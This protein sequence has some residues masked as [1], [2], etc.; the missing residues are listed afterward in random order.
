MESATKTVFPPEKVARVD[1]DYSLCII[2]QTKSAATLV[3]SPS[4]Y[5]KIL[6]WK[7]QQNTV[8]A[9]MLNRAK[10]H[11]EKRLSSKG[12][13]DEK[14]S[15]ASTTFTR[16][17]ST[18]Y[19]S[20]LCFFCDLG[21]TRTNSLHLLATGNAS[22]SLKEAIAKSGDE[23]LRVKLSTSINPTDAHAIDVKYH[24][25]CWAIHVT[26]VWRVK[27]SSEVPQASIV[28]EVAAEIEF[29][30]LAEGM[31]LDGKILN[32]G[33]LQDTFTAIRSANNVTH[34][35]CPR[36]V[37]KQLLQNEIPSIEFNKPKRINEPERCTIK[38]T[39][40]EAINRMEETEMGMESDMRVLYKASSILR[41][42]IRKADKWT[43]TG[44]LSDSTSEHVPEE[45]Y[46]FYRWL[47]QGPNTTLST[48]KE[49]FV[50]NKHAVSL[51]QSTVAKY[52]SPQQVGNKVT[53]TFKMTH[54]MP[55]QLAIGIAMRQATRSKKVV[56][57][58]HK[59]GV[60]VEYNRLLRIE[61]QIASTVLQRMAINDGLYMPPDV[62]MGRYLFFAV[63]NV[64]FAEDTTDG[65]RTL[66]ATAMAIYQRCDP[67]DE[68][69]KLE[70]TGPAQMRSI[71]DLPS[72][73]TKLVDCPKPTAKPQSPS[74]ASFCVRE[75]TNKSEYLP[76]VA[77]LMGRTLHRFEQKEDVLPHPSSEEHEE[78]VSATPGQIPTWS[79]YHSLVSTKLPLTRVGT[80][81]LIAAPA[82]EWNTLLT[83]LMQAQGISTKVVGPNHKTV[84][85]LDMGLYKPAKQ[86][87]MARNDM[88][89]LILRPGELHI[90]MAQLRCIGCYI[91]NSG[92]DF[93]WT[94]ADL[95]GPVT[96]RQILEG[97]HVKRGLNAHMITLQSLF[98]LHQ[99][100][101]FES[102]S[103]LLKDLSTA[104]DDLALT[105]VMYKISKE[106][107]IT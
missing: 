1:T 24:K 16:S 18:P 77:W 10:G 78:A 20:D 48:D 5:E 39:R 67:G 58:L 7:C 83:V 72:I 22:V 28:V 98:T 36:K 85:S 8:H 87:Q 17:H 89:H 105:F 62:V 46:I 2:C 106:L 9:G 3:Q 102:E 21:A 82:H 74:Y 13:H 80:P 29:L 34:P 25:R 31:M 57:M 88:D 61:G 44:N 94:E 15:Q 55:Q 47:I 52:L 33:E 79:A 86:L 101:F 37:I 11:Y 32:M 76:D 6:L 23:Q 92:L 84:V 66:H 35:E 19:K 75:G 40:D 45:L 59:F 38:T 81:P 41:R 14:S 96:V 4:A 90:V 95:Y 53:K 63:D 104:A 107:V 69:P 93:C 68:I 50:V 70:L 30:S 43:F 73:T 64:D 54:E 51:A 91:E 12:I 27:K 100:A 26:N 60:S 99:Q 56:D 65:K 49:Y 103:D 42:A 71:T 97:K